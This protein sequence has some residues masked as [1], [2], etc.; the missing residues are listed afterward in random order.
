MASIVL[1]NAF[2]SINSV[3]LSAQVR[4]LT[5][6][7]EAQ[8]QEEQAMGDDSIVNIAGLKNWSLDIT[9]KQ[10]YAAANVDATMFPLVGAAAFPIILRPDAGV[11]SATNPQFTGNGVLA[12]YPPISG[13]IGDLVEPAVTIQSAGT[14]ARAEA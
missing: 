7:Y 12:T 6:N 5:L 14:L 8:M 9:F 2:V 4:Q 10:D 1:T 13:A 3:D 11:V